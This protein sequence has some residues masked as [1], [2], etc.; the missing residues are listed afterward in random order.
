MERYVEAE[1]Y[2]FP[3][4]GDLRPQNTAV[5]VID[6]QM[7]FCGY[8]GWADTAGANMNVMRAP[9]E[10]HRK[11]LRAARENGF[12]VVYTREG[13]RADGSDLMEVKQFRLRRTGA[14]VGDRTELGRVLIRGEPGWEIV[15]ELTPEPDEPIVDKPGSGAFYSTELEHILRRRGVRNLIIMGVTTEVCVNTTLREA[16]DRGFDN[17]LLED[18]CAATVSELHQAAVEMV[19]SPDSIFGAVSSSDKFVQAIS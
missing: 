7:D 11:V 6:M 19:R 10:G 4:N 2:P 1:S 17:L 14:G 9:I 8:G 15:P 12:H 18:C 16:S 5:L 13:H 3:Y